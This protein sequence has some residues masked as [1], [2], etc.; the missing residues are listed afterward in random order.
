MKA[1]EIAWEKKTETFGEIALLPLG[2]V[3]S[4]STPTYVQA[5]VSGLYEKAFR[6][7]SSLCVAPF[8]FLTL[9]R[10]GHIAGLSCALEVRTRG[11]GQGPLANDTS[12]SGDNPFC[13]VCQLHL[14]HR[15][16][17]IRLLHL[18]QS[19]WNPLRVEYHAGLQWEQAGMPLGNTGRCT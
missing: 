4:Y 12:G 1:Y 5:E 13:A 3:F 2:H 17:K 10:G 19:S 6:C 7:K 9:D 14:P 8:L 15:P 16:T 11:T 18:K